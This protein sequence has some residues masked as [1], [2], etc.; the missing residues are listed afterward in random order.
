MVVAVADNGIGFTPGT[1]DRLFDAFWT[2]KD[3]GMGLGLTLS[4]SIIEANGGQISTATNPG[5]GAIVRFS[6]PLAEGDGK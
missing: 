6:L 2:T 3:G 5:G 4:R 1:S